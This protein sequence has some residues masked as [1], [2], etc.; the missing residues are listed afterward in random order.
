MDNFSR[1]MISFFFFNTGYSGRVAN[2]EKGNVEHQLSGGKIG[3]LLLEV[4]TRKWDSQWIHQSGQRSYWQNGG[5]YSGQV[6]IIISR[7]AKEFYE[8]MYKSKKSCYWVIFSCFFFCFHSLLGWS[9]LTS[10]AKPSVICTLHSYYPGYMCVHII[11]SYGFLTGGTSWL[12][13]WRLKNRGWPD[14]E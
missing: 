11:W 4:A 2:W 6:I 1:A 9:N 3:L 10:V 5:N 12:P 7:R 8:T 13:S 14:K